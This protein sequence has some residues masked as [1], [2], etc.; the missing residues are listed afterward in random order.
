MVE[1]KIGTFTWM[2]KR[3]VKEVKAAERAEYVVKNYI[4]QEPVLL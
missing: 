4:N 1:W 3:N 2:P